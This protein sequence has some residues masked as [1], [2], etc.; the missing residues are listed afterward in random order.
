MAA[1]DNLRVYI[2]TLCT[3]TSDGEPVRGTEHDVC[4]LYNQTQISYEEVKQLFDNGMWE[5]DP[6]LTELTMRQFELL[7][8][9]KE[10]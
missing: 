2:T 7:Q 10:A 8:D 1:S 6:R 5:Y 4:V 9:K 3:C